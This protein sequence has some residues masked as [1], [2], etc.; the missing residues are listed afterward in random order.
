MCYSD[1]GVGHIICKDQT[2][3]TQI[4]LQQYQDEI[5]NS[6]VQM[7]VSNTEDWGDSDKESHIGS[8]SEPESESNMGEF[9]NDEID[10]DAENLKNET[11]LES[12]SF[13]TL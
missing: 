13:D 10:E 1:G 11:G 3:T 5:N 12:K 9:E 2:V 7:D 4:K 6:N 8:E